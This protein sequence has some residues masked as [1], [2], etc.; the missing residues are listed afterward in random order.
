MKKNNVSV[1]IPTYNRA[2]IISQTIPTYIQSGVLEVIVIDDCSN[3]NTQEVLCELKKHHPEIRVFKNSKNIKQAESK[4]R[5]INEASGDYIY[6]GD[7]DSF[8]DSNLIS[9]LLANLTTLNNAGL[10]AANAIYMNNRGEKIYRQQKE[11]VKFPQMSVNYTK[12]NLTPVD[13]I[14]CP[15]CFI[16]KKE[17]AK[18]ILFSGNLYRG[19]GFREETDFVIRV[20]KRGYNTYL[21]GEVEQINL[22]RNEAS[23]GAHQGK[24]IVYLYYSIKNTYHFLNEHSEYITKHSGYSFFSLL[25]Y[26][27]TLALKNFM[28]SFDILRRI[29]R[30]IKYGK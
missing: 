30:V 22:P 12:P 23:G 19:N 16:I 8:V 6:F 2:H 7:D 15:A 1:V 17:L 3:D 11:I 20:R 4:N 13:S 21:C 5:G 29:Y 25:L 9:I 26:S 27:S 28:S 14:F 18:K 10:V 24:K